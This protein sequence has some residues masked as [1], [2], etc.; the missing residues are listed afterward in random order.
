[1]DFSHKRR[2]VAPA[3]AELP[4]NCRRIRQPHTAPKAA[5]LT[6]FCLI[7]QKKHFF[8]TCPKFLNC[9]RSTKVA[10]KVAKGFFRTGGKRAAQFPKEKSVKCGNGL[11]WESTGGGA[12]TAMVTMRLTKSAAKYGGG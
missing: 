10:P 6:K 9:C 8:K 12:G 1:M 5:K 7:V 4:Q 11:R 3:S 2:R